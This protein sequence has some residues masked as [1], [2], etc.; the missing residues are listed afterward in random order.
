MVVFVSGFGVPSAFLFLFTRLG[1][2]KLPL[3]FVA[4]QQVEETESDSEDEEELELVTVSQESGE[5]S[6]LFS[7]ATP[8]A[9]LLALLTGCCTDLLFGVVVLVFDLP[10]LCFVAGEGL[11][12][13]SID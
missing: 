5:G 8:L 12:L 10:S 6:F 2:T 1:S 11:L 13:L 7:A 9:A 3:L 4:S